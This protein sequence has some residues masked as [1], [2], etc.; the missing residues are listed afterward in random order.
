V[1]PEN[2]L[3]PRVQMNRAWMRLFGHGLV[4]TEEDFGTQGTPPT[5]PE[6]LDWLAGEWMREG[7]SLK[8]MLRLIVTSST[9]RQASHFRADLKEIDP[10]SLLL[11]RQERVRLDAEIVRDAGLSASGLLTRTIGGPSV[12][13]PQPEGVYAFTQTVKKWTADSGANRY[14]RGLYTLF[15]RSAPHPL[16]TTFDAPDFQTVCTRRGRSNTPLQALNVANDEAFL[17]FAQGLASR[18]RGEL[19]M[20]DVDARIRRAFV[21]ALCREPSAG[22]LAALRGYYDRQVADL[23]D[24]PERASALLS[25]DEHSSDRASDASLILVCRAI[26]NTDS[27]ITRE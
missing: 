27:F 9:Y 12:K 19:P 23:S 4:E 7:W 3:T 24:E 18:V 10:R 11:A 14:R 6:L 25:T 5:H 20:A 13:P 21:L 22:E 15:F 17:E 1:H 16:F 2:P 8:A 26:L